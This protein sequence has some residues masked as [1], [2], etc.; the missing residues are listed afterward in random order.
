MTKHKGFST[1]PMYG[2]IT[3]MLETAPS[4]ID[5]ALKIGGMDWETLETPNAFRDR[6]GEYKMSPNKKSLVRSDTNELME[7]V[8]LEWGVLQKREAFNLFQPLID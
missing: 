8:N 4:S 2:G 1:V 5:E 3:T 7:V 6:D